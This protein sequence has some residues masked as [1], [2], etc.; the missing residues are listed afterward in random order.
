MKPAAPVTKMGSSGPIMKAS[1]CMWL[2]ASSS[3]TLFVGISGEFFNELPS[4]PEQYPSSS[5]SMALCA[6]NCLPKQ[7]D[8][9]ITLGLTVIACAAME[10]LRP[11]V[12]PS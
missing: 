3:G 6:W 7:H 1:H 8:E 10:L 5:I 4:L 9:E 12:H 11:G 2:L